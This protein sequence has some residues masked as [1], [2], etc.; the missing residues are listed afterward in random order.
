MGLENRVPIYFTSEPLR[1]YIAPSLG[2]WHMKYG[3]DMPAIYGS[4]DSDFA[5]SLGGGLGVRVVGS[6][7]GSFLDL[8]Y[9]YQGTKVVGPGGFFAS[10]RIIRGKGN[11]AITDKTGFTIEA[12]AVEEGWY[13]VTRVGN[14]YEYLGT[15]EAGSPYIMCGPTFSF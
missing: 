5:L 7:T 1:I 11:L 12:G 3:L 6:Q 4:G 2:F 8:G 14:D 10:R 9:F 13:F 15:L